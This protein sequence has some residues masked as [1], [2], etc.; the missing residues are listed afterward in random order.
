MKKL[1]ILGITAVMIICMLLT[2]GCSSS[3]NTASSGV[4]E[5]GLDINQG[6]NR[7]IAP[8]DHKFR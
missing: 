1:T 6:G 5:H 7:T 3:Q 4:I 8:A 2:V